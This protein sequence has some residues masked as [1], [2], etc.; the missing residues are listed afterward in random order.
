MNKIKKFFL[1]L[2]YVKNKHVCESV[3]H[4]QTLKAHDG[5]IIFCFCFPR[6]LKVCVYGVATN[7]LQYTF[8][9]H[10]Y[11]LLKKKRTH[12]DTNINVNNNPVSHS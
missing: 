4:R 8:V 12:I 6:I 11:Y 3:S 7:A 5:T 1:H 2:N 10:V 9:V